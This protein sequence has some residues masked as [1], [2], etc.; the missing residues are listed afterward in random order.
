MNI[1]RRCRFL[2]V[3][4]LFASAVISQDLA[5]SQSNCAVTIGPANVGLPETGGRFVVSIT[6]PRDCEWTLFNS[7][8]W[9]GV[10][11]TER[12]GSKLV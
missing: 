8:D 5:L 2:N 10:I 7:T 3:L 6:A 9:L 11:T 4:A 12:T 1:S